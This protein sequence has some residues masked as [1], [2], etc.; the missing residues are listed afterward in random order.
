MSGQLDLDFPMAAQ[1]D[2]VRRIPK[3]LALQHDVV[4]IATNDNELVVALADPGD[5]ETLDRVRLA[6]G[7]HVR[8][9]AAS[10]WA[11]RRHLQGVYGDDV[12]D[13]YRQDDAP[14]VRAAD[15]VHNRAIQNKAS[16]IHLEP[17]ANG[18]RA[19][20]RIDG[21]LHETEQFSEGLFAQLISR[22]KLLAGLDIADRRQPQDGRYSIDYNGKT[23]DARVSTVPSIDGEKLVI[24]LLDHRAEVPKLEA[25]GMPA[26]I[27]QRFKDVIHAPHGFIVA[28]GPTGSGKTTTLYAALSSR[29]DEGQNLC[30]VEDPIELRVAGVT[31]VQV[32]PK[33][34]V[35]F[36]TALR[37]FL[38]QDPNVLM[39]GEMR[40]NDTASVATS[41]ALSGQLVLTTL[42]SND[43]PSTIQRLLELGVARN[44]IASS[45][46]VVLAQRLV[47][48]IC[49]ECRRAARLIGARFLSRR[50]EIPSESYEG[51]GCARCG[52]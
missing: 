6:T 26:Q 45:V 12:H 3:S 36:T 49:I 34:G 8:A 30:S 47:R 7:M 18:G 40:D 22:I 20:L 10:R 35:T 11:I 17:S 24:R 4:S 44:T 38:R 50:M 31:Q 15:G 32:N 5:E 25:L 46:S 29:N 37:S 23:I 14:A 27:L 33:A 41:A 13:E 43:A 19:R 48:K 42:H 21:I 2:V 16:D 52:G 9:V 28:S 39:V 1:P 51:T